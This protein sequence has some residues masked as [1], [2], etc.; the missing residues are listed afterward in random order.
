[1]AIAIRMNQQRD[2]DAEWLEKLRWL[3]FWM[4]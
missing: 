2:E 3:F 1:M 4:E